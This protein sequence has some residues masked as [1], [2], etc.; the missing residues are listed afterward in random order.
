MISQVVKH[1]QISDSPGV[2]GHFGVLQL[3]V[4]PVLFAFGLTLL[5]LAPSTS[6][7]SR[8]YQTTD[9]TIKVGMVVASD[10]RADTL[11]G[12]GSTAGPSVSY[13]VRANQ[14]N[15]NATVGVVIN[16][17]DSTISLQPSRSDSQ[18]GTENR[19]TVEDSGTVTAYVS[20]VNGVPKSG[21]LLAPSPLSG[22]LMK[23]SA[24]T[25][26]ISAVMLG[27][28]PS[29]AEAQTLKDG[30][31][32]KVAAA[33]V[34]L[35]VHGSNVSDDTNSF[36]NFVGNLIGRDVSNVRS[37]IALAIVFVVLLVASA[38][39]YS[40]VS[41]YLASL[42]RNPLARS[43]LRV[44]LIETIGLAF[45]VILVGVISCWAVLWL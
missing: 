8:S 14:A 26:G 34:S 1:N 11:S 23:A 5:L 35:N 18:V 36:A 29:Q 17:S 40:A 30:K 38:I 21:D 24:G 41:N 33:S 6:A 32:V 37:I 43:K 31:K 27:D 12:D 3:L 22:I 42:G 10:S 44:G 7:L 9:S 16:K 28:F 4:A 39:T 45:V 2:G 20:D 19:L 13:V 25:K 15:A